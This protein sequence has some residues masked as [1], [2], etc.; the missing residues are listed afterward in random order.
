MCNA[1]IEVSAPGKLFLVG[2]YAVLDG[3]PAL[4]TAVDRRATVRLVPSTS[5]AWTLSAPGIGDGFFELNADGSP[6]A[7]ATPQTRHD[8]RVFD[9][10]RHESVAMF[11]Q[12][13]WPCAITIDSRSFSADGHK[14]GLGS[15][16]AVSVALCQAL[17]VASGAAPT[18]AELMDLAIRSHRRA[19]GGHGSGGDVAVSVYGGLIRY[20]AGV[21]VEPLTWP[22]GLDA[23]VVATGTGA[24]T[25]ELVG[26]VKA[27]AE[28]E[29]ATYARVMGQLFE[30]AE[31]ARDA[32]ADVDDFV[33]LCRDYFEALIELDYHAQAGIVTDLHHRFAARADDNGAVFKS[34]GAGGGDVGLVFARSDQLATPLSQL[35]DD[36]FG[37]VVDLAMNAPGVRVEHSS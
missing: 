33:Q 5:G 2:E 25:T 4:L 12:P 7:D 15:S 20:Q 10:C 11:G 23:A 26:Q 27:L 36:S 34:C 35:F 32:T 37:Q 16:A 9:A 1:V 29:P 13:S 31:S 3:A 18:C 6:P 17:A 21:T 14:L 30:R 19:Q 24:D 28:A 22:T 8:L